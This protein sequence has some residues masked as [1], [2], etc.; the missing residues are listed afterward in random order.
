M[1]NNI[2]QAERTMAR[3]ILPTSATMIGVCATII[4]LVKVVEEH[5]GPSRVDE[6]AALVMVLFL[7]S[8]IASYLSIRS[9]DRGQGGVRLELVADVF[10]LVGLLAIAM[11]GFFFAYEVI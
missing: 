4:C 7:V 8:T 1:R 6:Y 5:S 9:W 3:I 10:F 11:V 2:E